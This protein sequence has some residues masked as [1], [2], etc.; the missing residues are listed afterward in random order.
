MNYLARA[1][2]VGEADRRFAL[3]GEKI[4]NADHWD[5]LGIEPISYPQADENDYSALYK[6]VRREEDG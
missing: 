5:A 1:L 4:D 3:I 6:G 2:P